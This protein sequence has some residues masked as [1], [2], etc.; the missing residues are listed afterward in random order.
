MVKIKN[1]FNFQFLRTR[2]NLIEIRIELKEAK[3][4]GH[5]SKGNM[6][7]YYHYIYC[8]FKP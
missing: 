3:Y 5:E 8:C 7:L 2:G 1:W 4:S 6:F